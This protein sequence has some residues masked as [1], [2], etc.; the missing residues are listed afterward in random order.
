ML[1]SGATSWGA[2]DVPVAK[3]SPP[4]RPPGTGLLHLLTFNRATAFRRRLIPSMGPPPFGDGNY[5][6]SAELSPVCR[7]DAVPS[8]GPPPF[9]DGNVQSRAA[10]L[11]PLCCPICCPFAA[12]LLPV[13]CLFAASSMGPPPF[14]DGNVQ[15]RAARLLSSCCPFN[16]VT[17]FRRW[18]PLFVGSSAPWIHDRWALVSSPLGRFSLKDKNL[19]LSRESRRAASRSTSR[20]L[21]KSPE[22]AVKGLHRRISVHVSH[23]STSPCSAMLS[24]PR[25]PVYGTAGRAFPAGGRLLGRRGPGRRGS[26]PVAHQR[27]TRPCTRP[28]ARGGENECYVCI[29]GY[30]SRCRPAP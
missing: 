15:S 14:G 30:R 3:L 10:R 29:P 16:G 27:E 23:F 18:K 17:A 28:G 13:C 19:A 4:V 5:R 26:T 25:V 12:R 7:L 21:R 2:W 22:I 9:G 8:M 6:R 11:L 24:A 20:R 1:A